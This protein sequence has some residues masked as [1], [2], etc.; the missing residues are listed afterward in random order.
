MSSSALHSI[1]L[2]SGKIC[3]DSR[4]SYI[5]NYPDHWPIRCIISK[6]LQNRNHY[7]L[8]KAGNTKK[9]SVQKI[10]AMIASSKPS[11]KHLSHLQDS[12]EL[13]PSNVP[14]CPH[15]LP[16]PSQLLEKVYY[17]VIMFILL[18]PCIWNNRN[19]ANLSL[20]K[21]QKSRT[22][23]FRYKISDF[24]RALLYP[25]LQRHGHL[26]THPNKSRLS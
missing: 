3:K 2:V 9:R 13:S 12:P 11:P 1:F 5:A 16:N 18:T 19:L 10:S 25:L 24:H 20:R 21:Q 17:C 26:H 23:L 22:N 15:D 4:Y 8:K 7:F 14:P 6:F